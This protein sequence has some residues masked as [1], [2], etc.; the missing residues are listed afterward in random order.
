MTCIGKEILDSS[1]QFSTETNRSVEVIIIK[2]R[3]DDFVAVIYKVCRFRH[4]AFFRA[5][6]SAP[7][8]A[9]RFRVIL[10]TDQSHH[11]IVS[12]S[13]M[14]SSGNRCLMTLAGLPPTT[15]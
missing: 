4:S 3:I 12:S 2:S 15:E 6:T 7:T 14:T 11:L 1:A 9:G 5:A 10:S 8:M 13:F